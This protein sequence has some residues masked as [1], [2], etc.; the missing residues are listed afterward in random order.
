MRSPVRSRIRET[1]RPTHATATTIGAIIAAQAEQPACWRRVVTMMASNKLLRLLLFD[2]AD[3]KPPVNHPWGEGVGFHDDLT[4]I[5]AC[6]QKH[7]APA[8]SS[9]CLRTPN[10]F[11]QGLELT[12]ERG[13]FL[14]K[15]PGFAHGES[16]PWPFRRRRTREGGLGCQP[17][18]ACSGSSAESGGAEARSALA[19]S[20]NF[21]IGSWGSIP[22]R[23]AIHSTTSGQPPSS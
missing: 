7:V 2:R 18:P 14:G 23:A 12:P 11:S 19:C 5:K 10:L 21:F 22:R 9:P 15:R 13:A 3:R 17:T 6:P 4:D 8:A 20:I 1:G 16:Q